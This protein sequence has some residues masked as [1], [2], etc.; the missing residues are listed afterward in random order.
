MGRVLGLEGISRGLQWKCDI[1]NTTGPTR[2]QHTHM[3]AEG[4]AVRTSK[5][6]LSREGS[7]RRHQTDLSAREESRPGRARSPAGIRGC[8][9]DALQMAA[10]AR[11]SLAA[12]SAAMKKRGGPRQAAC[13]RARR[14]G[15]Q[16]RCRAAKRRAMRPC[17]AAQAAS[18]ETRSH[19]APRNAA[20]GSAG[21]GSAGLFGSA[22][23]ASHLLERRGWD[24]E[25]PAAEQHH[26]HAPAALCEHR[27]ECGVVTPQ[28]QVKG[29]A[30]CSCQRIAE[31]RGRG[32]RVFGCLGVRVFGC[33]C[34]VQRAEG[35]WR[36]LVGAGW[37]RPTSL[38][39][40]GLA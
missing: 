18:G 9:P 39:V 25:R 40:G 22:G 23:S 10:A 38:G 12:S 15:R 4:A 29:V 6:L 36:A 35:G 30:T 27:H 37:Q 3:R 17:G 28:R 34:R 5:G 26:H 7:L 8:F 20:P 1:K 2:P 14:R 33:G 32:G 16:P 11:T 19:W 21:L 13:R 31:V 24:D